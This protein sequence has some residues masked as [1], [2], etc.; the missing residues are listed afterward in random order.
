MPSSRHFPAAS[1]AT[2][3]A[4]FGCSESANRNTDDNDDASQVVPFDR[5]S[6]AP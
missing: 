4:A 2:E 1:L 6:S 3:S 5:K